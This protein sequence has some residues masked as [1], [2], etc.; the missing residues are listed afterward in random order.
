[1]LATRSAVT[2]RECCPRICGQTHRIAATAK[3]RSPGHVRPRLLCESIEVYAS[4]CDDYGAGATEAGGVS[5]AANSS[6][7]SFA[8]PSLGISFRPLSNSRTA[9]FG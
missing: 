3:K 9:S 8:M 2:R 6:R 4:E 5:L 7:S 1:M